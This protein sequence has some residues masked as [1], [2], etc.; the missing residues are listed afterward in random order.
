M[1]DSP[2]LYP[3]RFSECF[4]MS[5]DWPG[6]HEQQRIVRKT[7][8]LEYGSDHW[9]MIKRVDHSINAIYLRHAVII[10]FPPDDM[11]E[12][13][14]SAHAGISG[15]NFRASYHP[16]A[17]PGQLIHE[18]FH[19]VDL[20]LMT[21]ADRYWFARQLRP[22]REDNEIDWRRDYQEMFADAGADW[23]H[24]GGEHWP[25]LTSIL[26]GRTVP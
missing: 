5:D 20:H 11:F 15:I 4:Q 3:R 9:Q 2:F 16:T 8:T 23:W 13:H 6:S 10:G 24:S 18:L 12:Q 21:W 26:C 7:L 1:A 17:L 14:R 19:V 22:G 25:G